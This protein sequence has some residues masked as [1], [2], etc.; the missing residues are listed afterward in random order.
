MKSFTYSVGKV[1]PLNGIQIHI[2]R[3]RHA[4]LGHARG[5]RTRSLTLVVISVRILVF[6]KGI[7]R[8]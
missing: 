2:G 8:L 3:V 7:A 1:F 6:G 4:H 5:S